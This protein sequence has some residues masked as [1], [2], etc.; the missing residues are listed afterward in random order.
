MLLTHFAQV[1]H[2]VN[3]FFCFVC[4]ATDLLLKGAAQSLSPYYWRA[5]GNLQFVCAELMGYHAAPCFPEY[6]SVPFLV[7]VINNQCF[8]RCYSPFFLH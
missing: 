5:A 2:I 3:A 4:I 7:L 6:I 1:L 8:L